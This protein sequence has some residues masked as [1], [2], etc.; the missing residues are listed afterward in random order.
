MNLKEQLTGILLLARSSNP[1]KCRKEEIRVYVPVI[2]ISLAVLGVLISVIAGVYVRRNQVCAYKQILRFRN[3]EF[4][5]NVPPRAFTFAELE[6]ATNE[7]REVLGRGA[8]GAVCKGILPDSEMVGAVK[9]LE[10]VLA[11]REKEFQNEI[12]LIGKTHHRNLMS[13]SNHRTIRFATKELKLPA[14]LQEVFFTYMKNV[15]HKIIHCDIKPRNIL[16]DENRCA[17]ISDF[18]L[19]KLLT[20]DQTGTY[21][22]FRGTK[23]YVAQENACDSQSRRLQLWN[24]AV[25]DHMLLKKSRPEL[26]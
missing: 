1:L 20:Y 4:L 9:K 18:G 5:E 8:F 11:E 13:F 2:R 10:K 3:V 12:K 19:A 23:G 21:T 16:M 15:G 25:G 14:T 6:Q 7:F 26:F 24:W 22:N 17:K